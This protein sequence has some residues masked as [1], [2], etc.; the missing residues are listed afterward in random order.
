MKNSKTFV[1]PVFKNCY[2]LKKRLMMYMILM[3]IL[4]NLMH[5]FHRPYVMRDNNV[6]IYYF[7]RLQ[8][9]ALD[10][11]SFFIDF[12]LVCGRAAH[13]DWIFYFYLVFFIQRT[14]SPFELGMVTMLIPPGVPLRVENSFA[15]LFMLAFEHWADLIAIPEV[16]D[17]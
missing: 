6:T 8:I 16:D 5:Y 12:W 14:V 13:E 2:F 15:K 10:I 7:R 17:Q 4:C 11:S 9:L 1:Y 3:K